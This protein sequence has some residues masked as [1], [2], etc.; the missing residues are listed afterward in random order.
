M[1]K[2]DTWSHRRCTQWK[3]G[4][5]AL[6]ESFACKKKTQVDDKK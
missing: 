4:T 2:V 5:S 6:A 1:Q 3:K